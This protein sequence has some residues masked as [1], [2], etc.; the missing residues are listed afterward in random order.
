M[1]PN[2]F[3]RSSHDLDATRP[4]FSSLI[5]IMNSAMKQ[6]R[7]IESLAKLQSGEEKVFIIDDRAY[8][9]SPAEV[10]DLERMNN[11][12]QIV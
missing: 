1:S 9:I 5:P 10:S 12:E 7:L 8:V 4:K 2:A 3:N 11:Y 6:Q